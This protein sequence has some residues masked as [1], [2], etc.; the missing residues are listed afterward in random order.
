MEDTSKDIIDNLVKKQKDFFATNKTKDISFRLEQLRKLK[1]AVE[2]YQDKLEDALW[3]DLHKSPEEAYLT[4]FSIINNEIDNHLKNLKTWAEPEK[5]S[6]PLHLRPSTS[7]ILYEPMGLSLIIAPWNYPFQLLIAPLIGS[8]SAGCCTILKPSPD[9]PKTAIVMQEMIEETFDE[10]YIGIVQGHRDTNAILLHEPFDFMFFTGSSS[11]GKVVMKAAAEQLIP[12]VLELGGKSP[13][14]VDADANLYI[15]AKRIAWGKLINAGQ[16][17]IAPDYLF[18]HH[19]IKDK[20]LDK[21]AKQIKKMYGDNIKESRFYPRIVTHKAVERLKELMTEGS[22]HTGGEIDYKE[23]FIA[24]TIIDNVKPEFKI[25]QEEIF[26]PI[27][28]VLTFN[29]I[30]KATNYINKNNKPLAFYYFGK[31]KKAKEVLQNTTSG[32]ACIND[33]LMHITNHNL[34]FGGVNYSGIGKY[35]GYESFLA[36]SNRRSIVN[37][38]T[39]I[40]MPFKYV[41]FR[42]FNY[43]KRIL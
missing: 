16:T 22:I 10:E 7:K 24:P 5:V 42:Y 43:I 21:I 40:D 15:A 4:E 30:D 41:P 17:C 9:A 31:N 33:T 38:P 36:F 37:T 8:I 32:G 6:T 3:Q 35:H 18:A 27:L 34:P 28:P 14:I 29:H 23:K 26:G 25:M 2:N 13:C 11:V 1:K 39:W 20:L 19:S 12:V